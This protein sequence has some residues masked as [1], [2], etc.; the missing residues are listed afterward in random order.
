MVQEGG[1][2]DICR[3]L[4]GHMEMLPMMPDAESQPEVG[5]K[6]RGN[7][8]QSNVKSPQ[9]K[10]GHGA[11][12]SGRKASVKRAHTAGGKA[13][14]AV[15]KPKNKSAPPAPHK[16]PNKKPTSRAQIKKK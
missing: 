13:P 14:T 5:V 8:T 9:Y 16:S 11:V 1:G 10:I 2:E 4:P 7:K 3:I 15:K 12:K 6:G